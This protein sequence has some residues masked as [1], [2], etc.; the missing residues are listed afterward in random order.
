MSKNGN[1]YIAG[2]NFTLPP[3]VTAVTNLTSGFIPAP[4]RLFSNYSM[5]QFDE[6][7]LNHRQKSKSELMMVELSCV[8]KI[9]KYSEDI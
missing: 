4:R 2:R 9:Q 1:I 8:E 3:A 5:D 7:I 6:R